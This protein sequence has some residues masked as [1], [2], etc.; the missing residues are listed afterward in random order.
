M[1]LDD[2]G[3]R[4]LW[5]WGDNGFWKNFV[6]VHPASRSAVVVFTN[7]S[8]GMNVARAVVAAATGEEHDAFLW[9]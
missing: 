4:Y 9:V 6:L 1:D 5:H 3:R 8:R 2:A 7:G